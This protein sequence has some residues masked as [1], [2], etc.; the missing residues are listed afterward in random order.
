MLTASF[1]REPSTLDFLVLSDPARSMRFSFED[2]MSTSPDVE[3]GSSCCW[4]ERM[5]IEWER[6]EVSFKCVTAVDLTRVC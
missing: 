6:L 4:S 1:I 2:R 5:R 3:L